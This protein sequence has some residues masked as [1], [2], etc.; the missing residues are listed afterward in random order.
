MNA[1]NRREFV[2]ASGGLAALGAVQPNAL[3]W[4]EAAVSQAGA[5]LK[6]WRAGFLDIHHINTGRGNSALLVMPDG[7]SLLVDAG[8][9]A[10]EGPAMNAAKPDASRRP[11]QWIA[12]YVQRQLE[13]NGRQLLDYALLTHLHGDHVGDPRPDSPR[14]SYG[15]YKLTGISDVGEVIRIGR[16]IDRGFPGYDYP[17]RV[18][19]PAALNYEAFAGASATRGVQVERMR[20]GSARQIGPRCGPDQYPEFAV[21]VVAGDGE[22]WAGDGDSSKSTFP[23]QAGLRRDELASENSCSIAL[24]VSYGKFAYFTGGDLT[25]DTNYGRDPWRDVET[26]VAHV[27][28]PVSVSTCNHHGYFDATG[29]EFVRALRPKV[30]VLQSWH[31]SHPAMP[32]LANLYSPVL[33]AGER[34]VFCLG[35]HP[36]AALACARFS[37]HF[38]SSQG[39]VVIRVTPGGTEFHVL[40]IED[41]D[42]SGRVK[43][44]LGPYLS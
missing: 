21:R 42:E 5:P 33:Y 13:A 20:V 43:T 28:G 14:S 17:V 3:G 7:T 25:C 6:P 27:T 11:G 37:D 19:D 9:S 41:G 15:E 4:T 8:A 2:R 31:A 30:W 32:V 26:A 40:V 16:L 36:A 29:P 1:W 10:T 22:V 23:S 38:K 12:R 34:D 39:H 18:T 35:L 24:R 44:V